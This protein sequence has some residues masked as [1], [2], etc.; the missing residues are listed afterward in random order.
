[1]FYALSQSGD[2]LLDLLIRNI[3]GTLWPTRSCN[4]S[5]LIEFPKH[6]DQER[7]DIELLLREGRLQY[8][9]DPDVAI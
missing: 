8:F 5:H 9:V 4:L 2:D 6:R 3:I 1:M 7:E